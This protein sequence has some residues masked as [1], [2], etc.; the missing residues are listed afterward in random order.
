[1]AHKDLATEFKRMLLKCTPTAVD[2]HV[3]VDL[4]TEEKDDESG[5]QESLARKAGA[6]PAT[7]E[8]QC[9][10]FAVENLSS[11]P[12]GTAIPQIKKACMDAKR[13]LCFSDKEIA[14]VEKKTRLQTNSADWYR[15]EKGRMS[16]SKCKRVASLKPTTSPSKALREVMGYSDILKTTAMREG[17]GK[18]DEIAQVFISEMK[19]QGCEVTVENCGFF[20]STSHGFIGASPDRI[21]HVHTG[22]QSS[23]GVLE[24]KYIQVKTGLTLKDVLLKQSICTKDESGCL[25]LNKNHKYYY[26]LYQQMFCTKYTWGFFVAYGSNGEFFMERVVF[27][28]DFWKPILQ[29]LTKF[30]AEVMLPEIVFP[31]VKYAYHEQNCNCFKINIGT[32]HMYLQVSE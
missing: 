10:L 11:L 17:L 8:S 29:K 31:R 5:E 6:L 9:K 16:A 2:L 23:P 14:A 3:L 27:K 12:E 28:E 21:I 30:Y 19:K 32:P 13:K 22:T 24:M 18:G 15:F 25:I 1:M 20:I 7:Q 4:G 26:Q